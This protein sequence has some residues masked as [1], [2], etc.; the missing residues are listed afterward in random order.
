MAYNDYAGYGYGMP[1]QQPFNWRAYEQAI[2]LAQDK[3]LL[4][5]WWSRDPQVAF[6]ILSRGGNGT[7]SALDAY[8]TQK[9]FGGNNQQLRD[10]INT[11]FYT[12][13]K[14]TQYNPYTGQV[15]RNGQNLNYAGPQTEAM[16][17][18]SGAEFDMLGRPKA[19]TYAGSQAQ[20]QMGTVNPGNGP[21]GTNPWAGMTQL[22][23][24][25]TG[26]IHDP[27][28]NPATSLPTTPTTTPGSYQPNMSYYSPYGVRGQPSGRGHNGRGGVN[29]NYNPAPVTPP[30]TSVPS[31]NNPTRNARP[32]T[33]PGA[34][35]SAPGA[36]PPGPAIPPGQ[37]NPV[38]Q[39]QSMIKN[40]YYR[41]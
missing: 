3:Q 39:Q 19:G 9:Y 38:Y 26:M 10:F 27:G 14:V 30:I 5:Y 36:P 8:A 7:S 25:K 29:N 40:N 15:T 20:G 21:N 13:D 33:A 2:R 35:P 28:D 12:G 31:A 11:Q 32:I 23:R 22:Y 37:T 18:Y 34:P 1:M 6:S 4:D 24:D 41:S 16:K 17:Y